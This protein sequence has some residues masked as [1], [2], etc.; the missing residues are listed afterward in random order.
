M[1][2]RSPDRKDGSKQ[3]AGTVYIGLW[4]SDKVTSTLTRYRGHFDYAHFR[5]V[6]GRL[7]HHDAGRAIVCGPHA[8]PQADCHGQTRA[9]AGEASECRKRAEKRDTK[10]ALVHVAPASLTRRRGIPSSW[11]NKVRYELPPQLTSSRLDA[12][13]RRSLAGS[14]SHCTHE[15]GPFTQVLHRAADARRPIS[16][17]PWTVPCRRREGL[18]IPYSL[19]RCL[20]S[21]IAAT[22]RHSR[23]LLS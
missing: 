14:S 11:D 2:S 22:R 10:R 20:F 18:K 1:Q 23:R 19:S 8:G 13:S 17:L 6:H 9:V 12:P 21:V 15:K 5:A 3:E 16:A 4:G 7:K